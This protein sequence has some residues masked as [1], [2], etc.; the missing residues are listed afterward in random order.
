[1]DA[2]GGTLF[3]LSRVSGNRAP[4]YRSVRATTHRDPVCRAARL[5]PVARP[6]RSLGRRPGDHFF[7][8]AV[9]RWLRS[10]RLR[11]ACRRCAGPQNAVGADG[12][13]HRSRH[14]DERRMRLSS[15]LAA[16]Q[17]DRLLRAG[18]HAH[19]AGLAGVGVRRVC[20]P[21]AV[22]HAPESADDRPKR[23]RRRSAVLPGRCGSRAA[24]RA[25]SV[26]IFGSRIATDSRQASLAEFLKMCEV[27]GTGAKQRYR[28][29]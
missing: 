22:G 8:I 20:G 26:S 23:S 15:Q 7:L 18:H 5:L 1:V 21:L 28:R 13:Q 10:G 4:Q 25:F 6:P 19:P 16:N 9:R 14:A 11:R 29:I 2:P 24:R 17:A 3:R 12:R 27:I